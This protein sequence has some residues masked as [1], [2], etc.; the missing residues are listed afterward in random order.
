M[1]LLSGIALSP[2]SSVQYGRRYRKTVILLRSPSLV[3]RSQGSTPPASYF[4]FVLWPSY[5]QRCFMW[6]RPATPSS[7]SLFPYDWL[8]S[9]AVVA[10]TVVSDWLLGV[11]DL[12]PRALTGHASILAVVL[13]GLQCLLPACHTVR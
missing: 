9:A 11:S 13:V 12:Q 1:A 3:L 5:S 6:H 7:E 2:D 10:Y 8:V 4:G